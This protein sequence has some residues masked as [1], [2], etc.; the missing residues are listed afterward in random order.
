MMY[1]CMQLVHDGAIYTCLIR[2]M[3]MYIVCMYNVHNMVQTQFKEKSL[4]FKCKHCMEKCCILAHSLK[5]SFLYENPKCTLLLL[6][7][8]VNYLIKN[9]K[10]TNVGH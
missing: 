1:I 5:S 8:E 6:E 2:R 10:I 7:K 3:Y 4:L 9:I